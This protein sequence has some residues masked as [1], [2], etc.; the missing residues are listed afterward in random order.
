M[1]ASRISLPRMA[2]RL[3]VLILG[4]CAFVASGPAYAFHFPWDSIHDPSAPDPP[5][6]FGPPP[7]PP[8]DPC[9]PG[10]TASPVFAATGDAIWRTVD[11]ALPGRPDMRLTRSYNSRDP[12]TSIF[13]N[14]W[15][16]NVDISL[17]PASR[18]GKALLVF[19]DA[20]GKRYE[21]ERQADGTFKSPAG[22]FETVAEGGSDGTLTMLDGRRYVFALDG[23]LLQ[24]IDTNNNVLVYNYDAAGRVNGIAD[25]RGRTLGLAYNAEGFVGAVQDHAGRIWRYAYDLNGN[26][27]T[28]TDP[29]GGIVRYE[30]QAYAEVQSGKTFYLM[31]SE[32]DASGVLTVEY[33]YVGTTVQA[34]REGVNRISYGRS[35]TNTGL[36]GT[37]TRQD[38]MLV[39]T[40]YTYGALGLITREVDGMGGVTTFQYDDNG[41][42]L[43]STDAAGHTW[44]ETFDTKGRTL[45]SANPLGQRVRYGYSGND[46]RPR[47]ITSPSGRLTA[48]T[49]DAAGNLRTVTDPSGATTTI[50]YSAAGDPVSITN[51]LGQTST[52]SFS[53]IG[54]PLSMTDPLGRI[55]SMTYDAV[56]RVETVRNPAGETVR[57]T[58]DALDRVRRI[59]DP[60]AHATLL[61]YD[62]AGRLTSVTDAKGSVTSYE[63]DVHGRR[64]AEQ[65]PDGRR[66]LYSY[67]ADNLLAQITWPGGATTTYQYDNNKRLTREVAGGETIDYTYTPVNLLAGASGPGGSVA[68]AY[69][70]ARRVNTQTSNG[71]TLSSSYNAEGERIGLTTP[72]GSHTYSRDA[73]G[74]LTRITSPSGNFELQYDALGRRSRLSYPNGSSVEYGFDAAGQLIN[75]A[76]AGAFNATYGYSYGAA[77]RIEALSG[78]PGGNWAYTYD[79]ASRLR[80][81]SQGAANF[82]YALDAVGNMLDGARTADPN[83]RLISD[84]A[85]TY[86]YDARGNLTLE[87]DRT[88]GARVAYAWNVK[89]QLLR[90]DFYADAAATTALRT[91]QYSYDPLGRRAAKIDNGQMQRYVYDGADLVG[92]LD[93]GGATLAAHVYSGAIDEPLA[94]R[95]GGADRYLYANHLGSVVALAQGTTLTH[96][97][98]Y[99]PYGET[100][101]GSS[102]DAA[103]VPFGYTG[104]EKDAEGLYYY[105][106]RYYSSAMRVFTQSDPIGLAGGINTYAYVGGNPISYTDPDGLQAIAIPAPLLSS[107]ARPNA[108]TLVNPFVS[109]GVNPNDPNDGG[110]SDKCRALRK[111]VE[112]LRKEVFDKRIP[113]L[114][115][116]RGNLP[117]RIGPGEALRDTVRGHEKLLNRQWRRLNELE[118]QYVKECGC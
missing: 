27:R 52:F 1:T 29:L 50:G 99:G 46:P 26:L 72:G 71:A 53:P 44:S 38:A 95:A 106:A 25:G 118:D 86:T 55:T 113:D 109:P 14:G 104:R 41:K 63:Y 39:N 32:R 66:T 4:L 18:S 81:A 54:L 34:Y 107:V 92:V 12:V 117:M 100:L 78:E 36:L 5:P 73:R 84:A 68:Y 58:Y 22:R 42:L 21:Y 90:V 111:K 31:L 6:P 57:Y 75:L 47:N 45:T 59:E 87:Q 77:G 13:G 101:A 40:S 108:G 60:L 79:A 82:T 19:K 48:M 2:S 69:D 80:S 93:A 51:A 56:G 10:A 67:R 30:W 17:Y 76:H 94:S 85:K 61:D 37:V 64:S 98:R 88:S 28:V 70:A 105:R 89:N 96:A 115:A 49:Y 9:K 3:L 24:Y 43:S 62:A 65:A 83:H 112:N 15:S 116:N 74:L 11:L 91:I 23:R 16:S 35:T 7:P 8:C 110:E 97:Y 102:A 20:N 33:E 103:L 114:A